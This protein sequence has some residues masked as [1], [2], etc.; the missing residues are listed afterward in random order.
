M[1]SPARHRAA[2]A[3][4]GLAALIFAVPLLFRDGVDVDGL[5]MTFGAYA[6][7]SAAATLV[8]AYDGRSH[9]LLFLGGAN[10]VAGV[11]FLT[12]PGLDPLRAA[13]VLGAWA[14]LT[15]TLE[16]F[17]SGGIAAHPAARWLRAAAG[18]AMIGLGS[19]LALFPEIEVASLGRLLG[20]SLLLFGLLLLAPAGQIGLLRGHPRART[21]VSGGPVK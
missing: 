9:S 17:A 2:T 20:A 6:L 10:L 13:Y 1:R 8:A 15:G 11:L 5:V 21:A 14:M 16:M 3:I 4:R 7:L 12:W 19:L 18:L